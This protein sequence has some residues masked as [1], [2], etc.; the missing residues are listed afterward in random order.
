MTN[1][2]VRHS[3]ERFAKRL[4][5][6]DGSSR[7]SFAKKEKKKDSPDGP[8][9]VEVEEGGRVLGPRGSTVLNSANKFIKMA[10]SS[11]PMGVAQTC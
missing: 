7:T 9:A 4:Y 1:L 5:Q 11:A 6:F 8:S 2:F 3:L 10:L